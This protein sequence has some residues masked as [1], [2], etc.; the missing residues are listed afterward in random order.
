MSA[1]ARSRLDA[2]P[3]ATLGHW[4]TPL[5]RADRFAA[6][7]GGATGPEIWLKRDDAG[8]VAAA[9]NKIRKYE[10]VL[11]QALADRAEVLVTTGAVQSNSARAGAAAAAMLGMDCVLVLSGDRPEVPTANLLLAELLGADVRFAGRVGW[12][13]LNAAVDGVVTE[14]RDA[15]RRAVAAPVGCS[16]PLGSL[17]FAVAFCELDAQLRALDLEPAAI[18]HTT[19][20]GGTHAGLLVGRAVTGRDVRLIGVDAG[21]IY[22][23]PGRPVAALARRAAALLDLDLDLTADDVEIVT[24][25][26]GD[27]YGAHTEEADGAIGLLART[28]AIVADP[29]Y[30]GK[31]LAGLVELVRRGPVDG[32][33]VFWH[34]GGYHALFDPAHGTSTL[35]G[36][37]VGSGSA[38]R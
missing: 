5:V 22:D 14:L 10:L 6:A 12:A 15:G 37:Q 16:S 35:E 29:I 9:G 28:E 21:R 24:T 31:G 32:P 30:S 38:I 26:V 20:S 18:V 4:P 34:T 25:Q 11:G 2:L 19:T 3:R 17:G 1:D 13:E 23:P 27:R 7:I 36:A 8:P 33:I